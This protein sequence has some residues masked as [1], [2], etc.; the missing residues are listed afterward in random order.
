MLNVER[1]LIDLGL[2]KP[3]KILHITDVH[4]Y[5]IHTKG[6]LMKFKDLIKGEDITNLLQKLMV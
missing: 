1:T 5:D 3:V 4:V 2:D 6:N